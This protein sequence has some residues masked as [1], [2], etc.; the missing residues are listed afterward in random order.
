MRRSVILMMA[1][2]FVLPGI[3][4]VP[5]QAQSLRTWVSSTGS[6]TYSCRRTHPCE[7][8]AGAIS[9]TTA[10][11]EINCVDSGNFGNFNITK[12]ITIRCEG[13]VAGV[14]G[15]MSVNAGAGDVVHLVGLDFNGFEAGSIGILFSTGGALVVQDCKIRGYNTTE[16]LG[17]RFTPST[18][19]TLTV[20]NT[21]ITNVGSA[22]AGGGILVS[23][24]G[25]GSAKAILDNVTIASNTYGMGI[26]SSGQ[27]V[28]AQI[29]NSKISNNKA[30]GVIVSGAGVTAT[31]RGSDITNNG[32]ASSSG[33]LLSY[34]DNSIIGNASNTPLTSVGGYQ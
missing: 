8:F 24:T 13:G 6:N 7:T 28:I 20:T 27:Q 9:K 19:A 18:A 30:T 3:A 33:P 26:I 32:G 31:I 10:G 16:S 15:G 14:S 5:V 4:S 22:T 2:A 21:S 34:L 29:K 11:G 1:L 23:A 25:S 17:I 12:A